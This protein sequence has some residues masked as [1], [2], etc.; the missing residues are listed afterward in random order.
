MVNVKIE[1][2]FENSEVII[3]RKAS[4]IINQQI[5][6]S[7]YIELPAV[8]E[9]RSWPQSVYPAGGFCVGA[10]GLQEQWCGESSEC[11]YEK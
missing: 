10:L 4:K 6:D 2:D 11:S 3:H 1:R 9:F 8:P 7:T 5:I